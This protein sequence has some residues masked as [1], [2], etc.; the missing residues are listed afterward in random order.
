MLKLIDG[1]LISVPSSI[2]DI[3]VFPERLAFFES[4]T[5]LM[6]TIE[7]EETQEGNV[8]VLFLD[9]KWPISVP[10]DSLLYL[11]GQ[12]A[13]EIFNK[14]KVEGDSAAYRFLVDLIPEKLRPA[15]CL[16]KI[17]NKEVTIAKLETAVATETKVTMLEEKITAESVIEKLS[18]TLWKFSV[19]G[20]KKTVEGKIELR[21]EKVD[22]PRSY[23]VHMES[24]D[25]S[26]KDFMWLRAYLV[27][28]IN[29]KD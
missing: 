27:S 7:A 1:N 20:A 25:L 13:M 21:K 24:R 9:D 3:V 18:D 2:Q 4:A 22:D 12:I 10:S 16:V 15:S 23:W 28:K 19:K 6:G 17:E 8:S 11:E 14:G 26:Y 5:R 29:K